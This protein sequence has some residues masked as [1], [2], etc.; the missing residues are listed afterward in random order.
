MI[1]S[2]KKATQYEIPIDELTEKELSDGRHGVSVVN[3]VRETLSL[4]GDKDKQILYL[5]F[6][7]YD[8]P[9]SFLLFVLEGQP[10]DSIGI[11]IEPS[12]IFVFHETVHHLVD[13]STIIS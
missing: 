10:F 7:N 9:A 4:L 2:E 8:N 12:T 5:Y 11:Q 1:I 3:S 13:A 6:V